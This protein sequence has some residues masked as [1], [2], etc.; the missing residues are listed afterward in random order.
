MDI[1]GNVWVFSQLKTPGVNLEILKYLK[2]PSQCC[3]AL[4][5]E[6]VSGV[7]QTCLSLRNDAVFK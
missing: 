4:N 5:A 1:S 2:D 7:L 6:Y 3:A